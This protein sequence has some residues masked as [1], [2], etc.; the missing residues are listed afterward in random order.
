MSSW[1]ERMHR[2]AATLGNVVT[3]CGHPSSMPPYPRRLEKYSYNHNFIC[4]IYLICHT[5][6][7][8]YSC[9]LWN[10]IIHLIQLS[11]DERI[12]YHLFA[13]FTHMPFPFCSHYNLFPHPWQC[14]LDVYVINLPL[15]APYFLIMICRIKSFP[16]F[17]QFFFFFASYY[18]SLF[19]IVLLG[20]PRTVS[21]FC[22]FHNA[23]F[24]L[25]G[26]CV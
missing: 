9:F 8:A 2:R 24:I 21:G 20:L 18:F 6:Y 3:S 11:R 17:Y 4:I 7:F 15:D 5:T 22:V 16:F 25:S 14:S 26:R 12:P 19:I 13:S 10:I 23:T 1:T